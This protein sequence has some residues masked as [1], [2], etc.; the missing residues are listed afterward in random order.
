MSQNPRGGE[1]LP[2]TPRR[3]AGAPPAPRIIDENARRLREWGPKLQVIRR[4]TGRST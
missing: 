4:G 1:Q 2:A 3:P